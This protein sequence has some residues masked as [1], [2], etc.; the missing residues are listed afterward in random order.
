MQISRTLDPRGRKWA[1]TW[2]EFSR[3]NLYFGFL[4]F[5]FKP[6][7]NLLQYCFCYMFWFFGREARG[8]L[9][10]WPGIKPAPPALEGKILTTGPPGKPLV[11]YFVPDFFQEFAWI[12]QSQL[13]LF[14]LF[15]RFAIIGHFLSGGRKMWY[16]RCY[17]CDNSEVNR[18]ETEPTDT[19]VI[20]KHRCWHHTD[21]D[22]SLS[23]CV[24]LSNLLNL[25]I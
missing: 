21:L 3:L 15:R 17:F 13:L 24:T 2:W 7:L 19:R 9:A 6:L 4:L 18:Q 14:N 1:E 25:R 23:R 10:P 11:L 8:I 5:V 20:T 16:I 22:L 12:Y